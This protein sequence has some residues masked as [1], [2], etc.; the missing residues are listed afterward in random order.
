MLGAFRRYGLLLLVDSR[1]PSVAGLVV[2]EPVRGS[3]WGHPLGRRIWLCAFLLSHRRDALETK[4]LGGKVTFVHRRLW[5]ALVGVAASGEPWQEKG[6]P[7]RARALLARVRREGTLQTEGRLSGE[8]GRQL[9]TRLLVRSWEVHTERGAHAKVLEPWG[10]WARRMRVWR[11]RLTPDAG[12]RALEVAA[13][14]MGEKE[15]ARLLLPWIASE[16]G[17]GGPTFSRRSR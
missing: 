13:A 17:P 16:G 10:R 9:E 14:R 12:R 6:L 11:S 1:L 5:P 7:P 4:L 8:A 2:G 3:W 15:G